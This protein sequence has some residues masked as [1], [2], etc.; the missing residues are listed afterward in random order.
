MNHAPRRQIHIY[1]GLYTFRADVPNSVSD[2]D[3]EH[4]AQRVADNADTTAWLV[5]VSEPGTPVKSFLPTP[6]VEEDD[7]SEEQMLD[8]EQPD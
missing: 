2:E 6:Y 1:V 4:D 3:A 7:I 5:Y 8:Q